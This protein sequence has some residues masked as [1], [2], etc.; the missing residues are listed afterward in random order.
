MQFTCF[1]K[2]QYRGSRCKL[3]NPLWPAFNNY[4]RHRPSNS[5]PLRGCRS[6]GRTGQTDG[7][8]GGSDRKLLFVTPAAAVAIDH[9]QRPD[10]PTEP[11][12]R[13]SETWRNEWSLKPFHGPSLLRG[14]G[15]GEEIAVNLAHSH[16]PTHSNILLQIENP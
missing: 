7:P 9:D 15:D 16:L 12:K 5:S 1:K 4:S 6:F 13:A 14:G 11:T 3:A 8:G 2:A 10:A